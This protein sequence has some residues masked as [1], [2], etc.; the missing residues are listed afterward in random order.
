MGAYLKIA[1]RTI[2]REKLYALIN[3]A[4]LGLAMACCLVLALYLRSELTYDQHNIRHKEIF[5]VENE[6]V[7]GG[8]EDRFAVTSAVLGEMLTQA[9][10]EVLDYVRF[11]PAAQGDANTLLIRHD[12]DAYYW[13]DVY[14]SDDNVFEVFTHEII[15]GDPETAL[16]EPRS[17]AVSENFA[18]RYFGDANPVGETIMTDSGMPTTIT[19]VFADLPDNTHMKY[20]ALF[21]ANVFQ[22]PQDTTQRRQALNGVNV[23]TFLVMPEDYDPQDFNALSEDFYQKNMAA[24]LGAA[25]GSW[26]AWLEPLADIHLNADVGYDRPT[27]NRY[28]IYGFAAFGIFILVVACIN[29]VNLSTARATRRARSVGI[30]KVLGANRWSLM[31]Q[32][33]G[34]A[35]LFSVIAAVV[36]IVLVEVVLTLSPLEALIDK[37]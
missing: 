11:R 6:F 16:V 21:S 18:R 31:A 13:D 14:F 4:G 28:Y 33:I 9:Y 26:R 8:G 29:Y 24:T 27:G 32:F 17:V 3:I 5:R 36:G 35:V 7:I 15:Y 19:L 34:E 2:Y 30:R 37:R 10:P 25:G 23:Y 20:D 22:T 1:W 12:D